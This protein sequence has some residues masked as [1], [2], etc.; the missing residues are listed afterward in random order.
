MTNPAEAYESYMVPVL[1]APWA[2]RLIESAR[3]RSGERALDVGCGTGIVARRVAQ[4]LGGGKVAAVDLS[5]G[6][7]AVARDA[8]K[9]EGIAVEW[10]EGRAEHLPFPDQSFDL[11]LCQFALMFFADRQAA[12]KEMR[13]VLKAG[14]NGSNRVAL[15]VFQGL[16]RHPFYQALHAAIER[17]LGL[18]G[19]S[20]IFAFDDPGTLRRL[21]ADAGFEQIEIEPVSLTARFP[22]PDAFLAG[23]IAVDT[24]SI[25][26]M[27]HLDDKA[28]REITSALEKD[29]A[30]PL[31]E[32]TEKDHVVLPFHVHLA[33]ARR[34]LN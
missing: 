28:R 13:R 9:R 26:S 12:L 11:V 20:E 15:S 16:A 34:G 29:M 5:P 17:R 24:A 30:K 23:E 7:L 14:S 8:A 1:F 32:A 6:M 25:P 10:H 3:P 31:H 21:L 2:M 4:Q 18:S 27:Q 19:V 33:R 22:D